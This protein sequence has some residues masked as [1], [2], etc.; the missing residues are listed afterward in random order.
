MIPALPKTSPG[1]LSAIAC[2]SRM[3]RKYPPMTSFVEGSGRMPD[4]SPVN[5]AKACRKSGSYSATPRAVHRSTYPSHERKPARI[6]RTGVRE[7]YDVDPKV[8]PISLS[9]YSLHI[10]PSKNFAQCVA[11]DNS[12]A[13]NQRK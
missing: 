9:L 7:Q 2:T 4:S 3:R 13:E 12:I 10:E 6:D 8:A 11:N 5:F 1:T